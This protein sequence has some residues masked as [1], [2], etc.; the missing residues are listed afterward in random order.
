MDERLIILSE[1]EIRT[2]LRTFLDC[3]VKE[4][5]DNIVEALVLY[6]SPGRINKHE[7]KCAGA[8]VTVKKDSII[9]LKMIKEELLYSIMDE[10]QKELILL[11]EK[12]DGDMNYYLAEMVYRFNEDKTGYEVVDTDVNNDKPFYDNW[13]GKVNEY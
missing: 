9:P 12:N 13:E 8:S 7:T 3:S 5:E 6:S 11:K 4:L 2:A 1:S 10:I